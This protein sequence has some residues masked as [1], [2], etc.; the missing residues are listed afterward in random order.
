MMYISANMALFLNFV[1]DLPLLELSREHLPC[2]RCMHEVPGMCAQVIVRSYERAVVR[3][4]RPD[5]GGAGRWHMG[6]VH[7]A[8][9][10]AASRA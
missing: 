4:G 2:M 7:G 6:E 5:G 1:C 9:H 10:S 8:V 3:D